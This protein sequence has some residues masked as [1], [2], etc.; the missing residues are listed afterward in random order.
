M[1]QDG[2]HLVTK[3]YSKPTD[4]HQYLHQHSSHPFHGKSSMTYS[5]TLRLQRIC[6]RTINYKQH[7]EEL[8]G[9]L[10]GRGYKKLKIQTQIDKVTNRIR[11]KLSLVSEQ[12]ETEQVTPLV[13]TYHQD[14]P[15]L[16]RIL[17]DH[18]CVINTFACLKDA[19]WWHFNGFRTLEIY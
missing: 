19:L 10:A 4:T 14:L 18:Q 12:R 15:H 16:T 6:S 17:Q 1:I 9:F 3:L 7:V 11:D 13:V 8:N 5:Q 2:N